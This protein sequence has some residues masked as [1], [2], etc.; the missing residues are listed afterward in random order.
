M[1]LVE[2]VIRYQVLRGSSVV[3]VTHD[4][5]QAQRLA[6]KL[7]RLQDGA[8]HFYEFAPSGLGAGLGGGSAEITLRGTAA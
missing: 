8:A 2:E 4:L 1:A 5:A 3:V 7:I 6:R